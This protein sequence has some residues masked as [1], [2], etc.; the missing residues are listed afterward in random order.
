M[1]QASSLRSASWHPW[2]H[3]ARVE[4]RCIHLAPQRNRA[5][6]LPL[7]VVVGHGRFVG[8]QSSRAS[9][10]QSR[11]SDCFGKSSRGRGPNK[12]DSCLFAGRLPRLHIQQGPHQDHLL[13]AIVLVALLAPASLFFQVCLDGG[14]PPSMSLIRQGWSSSSLSGSCNSDT[15]KEAA[16][17]ADTETAGTAAATATT[18][19][20][21]ATTTTTMCMLTGTS[22]VFTCICICARIR[23]RICICICICI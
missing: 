4:A 15:K 7:A 3:P 16:E 9:V 21:T 20:T 23:I 10:R 17:E 19:A 22:S 13:G 18:T 2:L 8:C 12:G 14:R 11:G 6:P 1:V 5:T